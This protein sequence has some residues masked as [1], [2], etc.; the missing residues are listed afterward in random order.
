MAH[1]PSCVWRH[2]GSTPPAWI[3]TEISFE[4]EQTDKQTFVNFRH[5]NWQ[6]ADDFLA[7]CSTK[8]GVFMMSIKSCIETGRG[9]PYPDDR[10][11]ANRHRARDCSGAPRVYHRVLRAAGAGSPGHAVALATEPRSTKNKS[12]DMVLRL[13]MLPET[14]QEKRLVSS[15]W[16]IHS[17][18]R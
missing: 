7:H 1:G 18:D 5:Y 12:R 2:A 16:T 15:C 11:H 10:P 6:Q 17:C 4:L 9:R 3:G 8:W 14:D 13:L